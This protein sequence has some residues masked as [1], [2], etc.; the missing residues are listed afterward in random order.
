MRLTILGSSSSGNCALLETERARVLID[1]GFSARKLSAMLR[2]LGR[3]AN[4]LDAVFLTHEHAD[5]AGGLRGLSLL[6]GLEFF[7]NEATAQALQ[8]E[9][10]RP[11][12]WRLFHSGGAFAYRD[13]TVETIPLPHDAYDPV[14]YIFRCG[15]EDLF[16][17]ARSLAWLTDLGHAPPGLAERIRAVDVLVIEANHDPELLERDP[18]RPFATKQRI[19]G[20]HGHLSN[21]AAL[22]FLQ[23]VQRPFWKKVYLAHISRDCNCLERVATLFAGSGLGC[24]VEIIDP[25]GGPAATLDL[26]GL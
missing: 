23:S 6:D 10:P 17:P 12:R 13:L 18:K 7:A 5:H 19:R 4:S 24:P 2:E 26:A 25:C 16:H 15:G 9:L 1:A 3:D 22:L 20:R 14:G 11:L 8:R 21:E